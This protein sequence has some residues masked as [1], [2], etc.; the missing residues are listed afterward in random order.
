MNQFPTTLTAAYNLLLTTEAAI[1]T[2]LDMDTPDD[3]GGHSQRH[4]GAN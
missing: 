2:T 4:R 1:G 3:N